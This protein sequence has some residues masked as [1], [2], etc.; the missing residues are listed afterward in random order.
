MWGATGSFYVEV[1]QQRE[2]FGVGYGE[3]Y[4]RIS[5]PI[6]NYGLPVIPYLGYQLQF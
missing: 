2:V 6:Y 4:E 1:T 5:D 3:N